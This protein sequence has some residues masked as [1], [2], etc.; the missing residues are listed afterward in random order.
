MEIWVVGVE[1]HGDGEMRAFR[2]KE[3]AELGAIGLMRSMMKRLNFVGEPQQIAFERLVGN[4]LFE[5][6][7]EFFGKHVDA[8]FWM[9]Q[10]TLE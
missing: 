5:E 8:K 10:V 3:K 1:R 2:K 4:G 9:D 7:V 6:A